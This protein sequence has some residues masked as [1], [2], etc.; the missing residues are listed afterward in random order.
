MFALVRVY[1]DNGNIDGFDATR[2]ETH[3]LALFVLFLGVLTGV[4]GI[5]SRFDDDDDDDDDR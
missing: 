1:T 5:C 4:F 3:L 2:E